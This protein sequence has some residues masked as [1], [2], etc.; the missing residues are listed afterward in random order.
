MF[1]LL[2]FKYPINLGQFSPIIIFFFIIFFLFL[3][4]D[5]LNASIHFFFWN[6]SCPLKEKNFDMVYCN[7]IDFIVLILMI[8][9]KIFLSVI[10]FSKN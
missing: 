6:Y 1:A 8:F 10:N 7:T 2:S 5:F 4:N 9:K 3:N